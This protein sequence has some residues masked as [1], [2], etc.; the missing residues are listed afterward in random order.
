ML[1]R[2]Y[3]PANGNKLA[4]T[5]TLLLRLIHAFIPALIAFFYFFIKGERDY[6]GLP[7]WLPPVFPPFSATFAAP[8]KKHGF[9]HDFFIKTI[10]RR[11]TGNWCSSS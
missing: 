8:F 5:L 3:L 10:K 11:C 2:Q 4:Q 1:F 9:Y 7:A 6:P